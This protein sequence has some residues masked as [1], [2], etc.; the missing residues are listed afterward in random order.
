MT[1]RGPLPV[2]LS[3]ALARLLRGFPSLM[4]AYLTGAKDYIDWRWTGPAICTT[5][6]GAQM[7]CRLNDLIQRKI[8]YFGV[9]EPNLTDFFCNSLRDGD[10]LVDVGANVG[11]YT[12]LG[13][14]LVGR[15]GKVIAIEASP[16]IFGLLNE[17]IA[18]NAPANV[19]AV[20]CAASYEPGEMPI[21]APPA[22][23]LGRA[24]TVPVEGNVLAGKV[25]AKPLHAIL[26][27]E[28]LAATRLIKID[29]EGAEEPVIR[30]ILENIDL[31][32][33]Q[34]EIVA[35]ISPASAGIIADMESHGF[36]A[37][38]LAN[39]YTDRTYVNRKPQLP[40]RFKGP[41]QGQ[42]DFIFSR[43]DV[44]ALV[45]RPIA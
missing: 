42:S 8:A 37:Y 26:T 41:M 43:R 6:F 2:R 5:E 20:N 15:G 9:W 17:N 44:S 25:Q 18:L 33:P 34:C 40:V 16:A 22:D 35:E 31:Y 11:Y 21:Y 13:S 23:N 19:R 32:N 14:S 7:H 38:E 39:D 12:L 45:A 4:Q 28:E 27:R 1:S 36:H 30:S 24:S 10:V 29:I 3:I